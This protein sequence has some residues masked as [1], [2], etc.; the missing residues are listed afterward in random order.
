[1]G[2]LSEH[3]NRDEFECKCTQCGFDTVDVG[4]INLLEAVRNHFGK[5]VIISSGCRCE[6]HNKAEGGSLKSQHLLGRAADIVVADTSPD[7]VATF[8]EVFGAQGIGR[9]N[10]FTHVDSRSGRTARW[11]G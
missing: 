10:S 4:L 6:A 3:F 5:P 7:A 11:K 8:L 1:M 2:D 9:Y